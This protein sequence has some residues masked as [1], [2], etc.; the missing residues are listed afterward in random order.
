MILNQRI[1]SQELDEDAVKQKE[2]IIDKLQ[3][4]NVALK[5]ENSSLL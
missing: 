4:A 2:K 5:C 1:R 3:K